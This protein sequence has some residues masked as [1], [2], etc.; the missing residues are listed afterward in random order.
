MQKTFKYLQD[1]TKEFGVSRATTYRW[2]KKCGITIRKTKKGRSAIT[3]EDYNKLKEYFLTEEEEDELL[4]LD[5]PKMP[6]FSLNKK[7]QKEEPEILDFETFKVTLHNKSESLKEDLIECYNTYTDVSIPL[8]Q[9]LRAR[10]RAN[11]LLS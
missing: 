5:E 11:N 7:E 6:T 10:K 4:P 3:L 8:A 1:V 2:C 9:R